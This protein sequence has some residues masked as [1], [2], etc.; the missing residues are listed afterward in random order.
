MRRM[1][2]TTTN[3]IRRLLDILSLYTCNP[4]YL[5][6]NDMIHSDF[7][8]M[9][10]GDKSDTHEIIPISFISYSITNHHKLIE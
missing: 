6:G 9:V 7:L 8:S 10:K 1:S 5:K 3:G 4:Y 2:E